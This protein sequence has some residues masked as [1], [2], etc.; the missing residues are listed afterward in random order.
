MLCAILKEDDS[1]CGN[2]IVVGFS[3]QPT[4]ERRADARV[5]KA[6]LARL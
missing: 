6:A 3:H 4:Q 2:N 1:C 5:K